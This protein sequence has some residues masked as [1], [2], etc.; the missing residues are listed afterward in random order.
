[1]KLFDRK[2]DTAN[3]AH[4]SR[5]TLHR[6]DFRRR[7]LSGSWF[8]SRSLKCRLYVP[9]RTPQHGRHL[10]VIDDREHSAVLKTKIVFVLKRSSAL[11]TRFHRN[12]AIIA[13][14]Q[15]AAIAEAPARRRYMSIFPF[16]LSESRPPWEVAAVHTWK[17]VFWRDD[18]Y[19]Q[20]TCVI[21]L[22]PAKAFYRLASSENEFF[23]VKTFRF[24]EKSR[25]QIVP[26]I[27]R[28]NSF[29]A[30][31]PENYKGQTF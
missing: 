6:R 31:R 24:P 10:I 4:F 18:H 21:K 30:S 28:F 23:A 1:M 13:R 7:F 16:R 29:T 3:R 17:I 25:R 5:S 2:T 8:G 9:V 12:A 22:D 26:S 27:C 14:K 15:L 20:L 11:R 19:L